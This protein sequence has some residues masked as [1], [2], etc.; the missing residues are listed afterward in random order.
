MSPVFPPKPDALRA[1]FA[2]AKPIIGV[3]HLLPLPGAPRYKGDSLDMIVDH[4]LTDT[5]SFRDGGVDGIIVENGW[6]LPFAKPD[7]I[8][9]ETVA[10]MTAVAREVKREVG[11]PVGINCLAN[12]AIPSLAVAKA[13]GA[14]FVRVNQWANAYVA[15]EGFIE[16]AA[17]K[18][19]RYRAAIRADEVSIFAD[20]H[21]KHGSHAIVAD[22]TLAEQTRDVEWFDADVLIATGNRTGDPTPVPEIE[23]IKDHASLPVIVG[24]GL[25]ADNAKEILTHADG[26][27]VATSLKAD[28]VWWNPVDIDRVRRLMDVVHDMRAVTS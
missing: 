27:I 7:D 23:G 2:Q 5:A 19:M 25:T 20:V 6:D 13:S 28:G 3:L 14:N 15:N 9:V 26:A 21:V 10:A 18:A 11:L 1:L 16:G 22:R 24:S 17:A 8:G 4:A 12:A